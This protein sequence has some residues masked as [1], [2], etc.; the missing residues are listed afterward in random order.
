[1]V[2]IRIAVT[3]GDPTGIGPEVIVKALAACSSRLRASC[4]VVGDPAVMNTAVKRFGSAELRK[5]WAVASPPRGTARTRQLAFVSASDLKWDRIQPGQPG[6]VEGRAMAAYLEAGLALVQKGIC[7][8]LVTAPVSKAGLKAGGF[9]YPGHTDWLAARTG[10]QAVMMLVAGGLRVVPVTVHVPLSQAARTITP[11]LVLQTLQVVHRDLLARFKIRSPRLYVSGLNPHAGEQGMLGRE[12]QTMIA[13]AIAAARAQ[14]ILASG[15][16]P[17]DT[18][19]T[20][21]KRK[22]YDAA[23]CMYHDQAL[24]P[25][26]TLGFHRAVNVTLGLPLIRT[27]PGH[28]AAPDIAGQGIA[29][30]GAMLKALELAL[31][32]AR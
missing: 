9:K 19:F 18:M 31:R 27:S 24:I 17:A 25:V 30:P 16:F 10:A 23:V 12:E 13:P 28:G 8:A 20:P 22:A 7:R 5:I 4:V 15:P 21:E 3:M 2:M 6:A 26:K 1:M 29:H 11:E 32:L 14:G